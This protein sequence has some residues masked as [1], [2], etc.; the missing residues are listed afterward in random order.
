MK[1]ICTWIIII[2]VVIVGGF[3]ALNSYIYQEKQGEGLPQDF[4]EATFTVSGEPVTLKDGVAKAYT[5]LGGASETTIRYFGN[6]LV[7]DVDG[8]GQE[9]TVFLVSQET[10][11][12]GTFFYAVAALKR[13]SGYIGSQAVLLGDRIAPQ[14]TEKADGR[15]IVINYMERAP[16]EP[17]TTQ[18]SVG[19]SLYLLLD[20]DS[21]QFGELV[22]N[23]EGE[24]R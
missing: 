12:S 5:S 17:M 11:G 19:K 10:G 3:F 18:P 7:H 20:T 13:G 1:T 15:T 22:Q 8:D 24:S 21:L 9:D 14:T 23:F 16:G 6:E 2:L 4:K